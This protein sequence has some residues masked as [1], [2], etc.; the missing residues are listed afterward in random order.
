ME[1]K[2]GMRGVPKAV[3]G[4]GAPFFAGFLPDFAQKRKKKKGCDTISRNIQNGG[5]ECL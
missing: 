3:S 4:L 2:T 5:S 1:V